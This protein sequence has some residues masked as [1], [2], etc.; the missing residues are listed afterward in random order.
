MDK[1]AAIDKIKKCLALS[2]SANENEAATAIRQARALMD[3]FEVNDLELLA[4][5]V[6]EAAAKS[7]VKR[8]PP[9]WETALA[10]T[11]A[12]AF[13]C[14]TIY[15]RDFAG[16]WWSFVGCSAAPDIA[17]YA[18]TVLIRQVKKARGN[19]VTQHCKRLIPASKTRRADLFCHG[20]VDGVA[21]L[22]GAFSGCPKQE[23]AI[24]AY[25]QQRYP[26]LATLK[27]RDRNADRNFRQKDF[28]ASAAGRKA[29]KNAQLNRGVAGGESDTLALE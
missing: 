8:T 4:A 5:D 28:D 25:V 21:K 6:S 27:D 9:S 11:V 24:N 14:Q 2:K 15:V 22:I 16:S 20:W 12:D 1:K 10:L 26:S 18:F 19:F 7:T 13:N 29:G 3:K 17:E 23:E